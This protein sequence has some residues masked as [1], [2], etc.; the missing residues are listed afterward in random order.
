MAVLV[1]NCS[2]EFTVCFLSSAVRCQPLSRALGIWRH[3]EINLVDYLYC[4]IKR[5]LGYARISKACVGF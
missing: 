4:F 5:L 1:Q 2:S 3:H